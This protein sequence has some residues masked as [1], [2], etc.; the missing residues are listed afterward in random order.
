MNL[1]TTATESDVARGKQALKASLV[2]QLN[3]TLHVY[4]TLTQTHIQNKLLQITP[5]LTNLFDF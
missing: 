3:G 1:C 5:E 4:R 2:G